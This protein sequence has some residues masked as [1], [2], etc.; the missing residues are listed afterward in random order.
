MTKL[1]EHRIAISLR[2]AGK[3]YSQIRKELRLSKSTL[4]LW[5][6][7]FPLSKKQIQELRKNNEIRIEKYRNTRQMN[8][9][10]RLMNIYNFEKKN[11]IPFSKKELL[12]AGLFLYLG[13]GNKASNCTISVNNTD[14]SVLKFYYYWLVKSFKIPKEKIKVYLHLYKD[15]D[16]N[17]EMNYWIKELNI[18]KNQ[19]IKPYIKD[20][21]R[22]DLDQKGF[23]HGTCGLVFHKTEIKEKILMSIRAIADYYGRKLEKI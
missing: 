15:M 6:K 7:N 5:L 9:N 14:P 3:S 8:R 11:L 4:S 22:S 1:K 20:S 17:G 18:S 13:E 2:K 12:I 23:G 19:F 16:I 21:K 10:K